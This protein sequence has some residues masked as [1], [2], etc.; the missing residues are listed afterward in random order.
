MASAAT[1]QSTRPGSQNLYG[2]KI[3]PMSFTGAEP[4]FGTKSYHGIAMVASNANRVIGRITSWNPQIMSREGIHIYEL[5]WETFGIPIDY[6]PGK[7]GAP[8]ASVGR[9][10]VWND[11]FEKALFGS[12]EPIWAHLA[13]QTKPFAV[14][15]YWYRGT[16][17]YRSFN[18]VGCWFTEKAEDSYE[19]EGDAIVRISG[20]I[21]FI[22]RFIT[23]GGS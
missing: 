7:I 3:T 14:D 13:D 9:T 12:G 10:E 23:M 22:A 16:S 18:Y 15:E 20:T 5:H 1:S 17:L 21:N 4:A 19:A 11:E 8:T 6:V 2:V